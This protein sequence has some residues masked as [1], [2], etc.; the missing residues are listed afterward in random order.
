[1]AKLCLK[2]SDN[3]IN[4][5]KTKLKRP[6]D[7]AEL[8]RIQSVLMIDRDKKI[9]EIE[10]L[11]GLKRSRIFEL[12]L[13]FLTKG[14][15]AL[16]TSPKKPKSLLTK[17]QLKEIAQTLKTKTPDESGY[18]YP[19]WTTS[20]LS[21]LIEEKYKVKYKSKT[22]LYVV[23]K[24]AKFTYHKPGRV[25]EKQ[26]P[27]AVARWPKETKPKI[28]KAFKEK[29]TIILTEDEMILST[30]TTFQKIWLPEGEY[31][32]VEISN[33][34]KNRSVYGFLNI[35]TGK[36]HAFK[37]ERQ[38]M[39]ITTDILKEIRK[40]YPKQKLLLLWD[41][42]GWHRG[43]KTQEFIKKD[44]KIK[45]IYFPKYTPEENPQEH[46]WKSGRDQVTHNRFI[47]NIDTATNEFIDYLNKTNFPYSLLGFSPITKC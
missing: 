43:S 39:H 15:K 3:Q 40:I 6:T 38:N 24:E 20:V 27:E 17:N 21:K 47:E 28:K 36:C 9:E 11:T 8:K 16:E 7:I 2:F 45:T 42:A 13:L 14:L 19:F 30:Q 18:N 31:P 37:T 23:F 35:K 4:E 46:V 29:D 44:Q 5:L 26:D 12:R 34:R 33:T 1:M 41:G 25:Y 22:S 10:W 32:K